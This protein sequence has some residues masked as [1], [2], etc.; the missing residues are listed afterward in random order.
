MDMLTLS[1]ADTRRLEKLAQAT[2]RTPRS[3][4]KHVMRDGF[5]ATEHS[6]H[7]VTSRMQ[8]NQRITHNAAMQQLDQMIQTHGRM[9]DQ[10]RKYPE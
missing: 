5:E 7:A 9:Y 10:R 2:G 3:V 4:L 8:T 6:V 1:Q